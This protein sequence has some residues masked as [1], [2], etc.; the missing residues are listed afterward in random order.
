MALGIW[1]RVGMAKTNLTFEP[2]MSQN[3]QL[4]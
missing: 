2:K 4:Q 3:F 1:L